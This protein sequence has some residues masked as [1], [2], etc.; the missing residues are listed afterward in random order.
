[1]AE[2]IHAADA[3]GHGHPTRRYPRFDT[4]KS[5]HQE[6]V[7]G[8]IGIPL[9]G[10]PPYALGDPGRLTQTREIGPHV[11]ERAQHVEVVHL[12]ELA[13]SAVEE[14]ELPQCQ[15]LERA[16]E[17]RADAAGG[18]GHAADLAVLPG[19]ERDDPIAL[20]QGEAADD[21]RRR[22]AQGHVRK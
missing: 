7:Q 4:A 1:M 14:H 6:P 3:E 17:A 8:D 22:L 16:A 12:D 10:E 21:D 11:I 5:P 19:E 18:P 15:Q 9:G 2:H 13:P 20:P